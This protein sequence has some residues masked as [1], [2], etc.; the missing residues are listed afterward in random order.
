MDT[1]V[2]AFYATFSF[3]CSCIFL[4]ACG[5]GLYSLYLTSKGGEIPEEAKKKNLSF[6]YNRAIGIAFL[7]GGIIF[8]I[9]GYRMSPS[10]VAERMG[11]SLEAEHHP[12]EAVHKKAHV[13]KAGEEV[14]KAEVKKE[15]KPPV[16]LEEKE[17]KKEVA[18]VA[19]EEK[20]AKERQPGV[21]EVAIRKAA[22]WTKTELAL[23]KTIAVLQEQL[24]SLKKQVEEKTA[25]VSSMGGELAKLKAEVESLRKENQELKAVAGQG[26]DFKKELDSLKKE[27]QQLKQQIAKLEKS[28]AV[29]EKE[30]S[31]TKVGSTTLKNALEENKALKAKIS[32]MDAELA[33]NAKMIE[34]TR[35]KI[36]ELSAKLADA[37]SKLMVLERERDQLRAQLARAGS[38]E[39]RAKYQQAIQEIEALKEK[40][41]SLEQSL[42]SLTDSL[43]MKIIDLTELQSKY[44]LLKD[45]AKFRE[46]KINKLMEANK[47]MQ[48][49]LSLYNTRIRTLE[50]ELKAKDDLIKK[51]Q[52]RFGNQGGVTSAPVTPQV[53]KTTVIKKMVPVKKQAAQETRKEAKTPAAGK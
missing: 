26:G 50:A 48:E 1:A 13:V 12:E 35:N 46:E 30:L 49:R 25:A 41:R 19:K 15:E 23:K 22:G 28:K 32:A 43:D 47:A 33:K 7:I 3:V 20:P 24:K 53:Q 31:G 6:L 38:P 42:K 52:E 2:Y 37:N 18:Q 36:S 40:N 29:L 17:A 9:A 5:L 27:N 44:G 51:L 45:Q 4:I 39:L 8:G 34:E 11:I 14:K 16:R 10:A 21:E